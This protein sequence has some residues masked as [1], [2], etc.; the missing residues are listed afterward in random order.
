[1]DNQ[2]GKGSNDL[3]ELAYTVGF[4]LC[5]GHLSAT[6][7][8]WRIGFTKQDREPLEKCAEELK[9]VFGV[10]LGIYRY[11][12]PP[13]SPIY[14]A[15]LVNRDVHDWFLSCTHAKTIVPQEY[16]SA[17]Q[18]V[19]AWLLA[20]FMDGDMSVSQC[21]Q[22]VRVEFCS[23]QNNFAQAVLSLCKEFRIKTGAVLFQPERKA[24]RLT[25]RGDSMNRAGLPMQSQRKLV[26]LRALASETLYAETKS[27]R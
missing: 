5:D 2:Q 13:H 4:W 21:G 16:F 26:K 18:A 9:S 7:N 17:P 8:Q 12:Y 24:W 27:L 11:H 20:G 25:I 10:A 15:Q 22:R 19:K 14:K 1:M 3:Y 6:G 23:L